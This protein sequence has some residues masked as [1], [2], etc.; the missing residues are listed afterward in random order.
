MEGGVN[1]KLVRKLRT[2][3]Y[4]DSAHQVREY[5]ERHG[6]RYAGGLRKI[7]QDA[8]QRL[9]EVKSESG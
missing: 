6:T 5:T 8:K 1:A 4:K 7:Y 9:R 3:V 2:A